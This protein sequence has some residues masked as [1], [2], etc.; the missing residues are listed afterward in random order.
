[1]GLT[2]LQLNIRN[3]K[4]NIYTLNV[5]LAECQPD[6][7]LLNELGVT[8]TSVLKIRGYQGNYINNDKYYGIA[9]FTKVG[10]HTEY[11]YFKLGDI[12]AVKILTTMGQIIIATAY[13]PPKNHSIPTISFNYL[14][15]LK[16]PI[17]FVGDLN[18]HAPILNNSRNQ[19]SDF[20]GKQI[21]TL[22]NKFN[23]AVLG[24]DFNTFFSS[25]SKGK[26]DIIL[27]NNQFSIFNHIISP[28][29][30]VGSDHIPIIIKFQLRP[31]IIIAPCRNNLNSIN[32]KQFKEELSLL[33]V[34]NL[35]GKNKIEISVV[36]EKLMTAITSATD[37]NCKKIK[38]TKV[39]T[40]K[41]TTQI[42]NLL[43]N[44]QVY[45]QEYYFFGY[46]NKLI[47]NEKLEMVTDL[48]K[49][50]YSNHWKKLVKT[51]SDS[52]GDVTLF[53][54]KYNILRGIKKKYNNHYLKIYEENLDS[55]DSSDYGDIQ[56]TIVTNKQDQANLM[57]K[58]WKEIFTDNE[59]TEKGKKNIE[60]VQRWFEDNRNAFNQKDII[61]F[62]L[63]PE[64]HPL[65]R[66]FDAE[67]IC[68]AIKKSRNRAPGPSGISFIQLKILPPN[69]IVTLIQIFNGIL[70][71]NYF[72]TPTE[73]MSLIFIP[74]PNKNSSD[75]LN[76]RPIT[77][78]ETILKIL[79][80]VLA[81]RLQ[82]YLEFHNLFTEKQ[83]GFRSE[84]CTQHP[85][86][87]VFLTLQ[88]HSQAKKPTLIATRDLNKAFDRVHHVSLM[89]KL[90]GITNNCLEFAAVIWNF[91]K[92]R[93]IQPIFQGFKGEIIIPKSGVPQGSSTGPVL[94]NVFVNDSPRPLFMDTVVTQFADDMVHVVCSDGRQQGRNSLKQAKQKMELE[95]QQTKDWEESWKISSNPQKSSIHYLN[96]SKGKLTALGGITVDNQQI[97]INNEITIL[98]AKMGLRANGN[99]NVQNAIKKATYNITKLYRFK[100]APTKV[101]KY[102]F[103]ALIRPIFE[104]PTFLNTYINKKTLGKLQTLQ[105]RALRFVKNVKLSDRIKAK[106]MHEELEIEPVNVRLEKLACKSLNKMKSLYYIPKKN[107]FFFSFFFF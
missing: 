29:N 95:L 71:T 98:G 22:I 28:G 68:T 70:C 31:F 9:I 65:M 39:E 40:Y 81:Q 3:F 58:V 99:F 67:E 49:D 76:F 50:T 20:K 85:I 103:K 11:V 101:K 62:N 4:K 61:D 57:S 37:N 25:R 69:C 97:P 26:P 90:A 27:C 55:S 7:I 83:F 42:K 59:T 77:L 54:K 63:L 38:I 107:F 36:T 30:D 74:K 43:S 80:K 18:G 12:L 35:Q 106:D 56:E 44:Y 13:S 34:P 104:Y 17:L 48:I 23:L 86:S 64:G 96:T 5:D 102:L 47:L 32:I 10:L 72:P 105:N 2:V 19:Y 15:S 89:F 78:T 100:T 91:L 60:K 24:P 73:I 53:W 94:F 8:S 66:P 21:D 93:K 84:R 41:P 16:L 46:H 82:Y 6:V 52:Y 87:L 51:A 79:D 45:S 75:P 33:P 92:M 14:F 1:M 88:S